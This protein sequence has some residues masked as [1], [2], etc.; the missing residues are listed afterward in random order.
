MNLNM[1]NKSIQ[2]ISYEYPDLIT[3]RIDETIYTYRSSEYYCRRF[4]NSYQKGGR[5]NSF[6]LFKSNSNL[7]RKGE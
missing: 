6:N 4:I 3:L 5:F 1:M 7:I 2:F